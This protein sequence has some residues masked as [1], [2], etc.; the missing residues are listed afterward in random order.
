MVL[1]PGAEATQGGL[2]PVLTQTAPDLSNR[3]KMSEGA[4]GLGACFQ[5]PLST[6]KVWT[7]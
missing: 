1:E 2:Q 3:L 7:G 5:G 4:L 6:G